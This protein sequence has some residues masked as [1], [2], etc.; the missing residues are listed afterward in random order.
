MDK[1]GG[2]ALFTAIKRQKLGAVEC[3]LQLDANLQAKDVDGKTPLDLAREYDEDEAIE[4]EDD[5]DEGD[6]DQNENAN[7]ENNKEDKTQ[8][9]DERKD[10]KLKIISLLETWEKPEQQTAT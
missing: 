7:S 5:D 2:T 3:L 1:I 4:E 9:K 10:V 6:D 8:K